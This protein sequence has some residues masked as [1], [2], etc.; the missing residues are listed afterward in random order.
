MGRDDV[1][2]VRTSKVGC[3]LHYMQWL[4]L[5]ILLLLMVDA[6]SVRNM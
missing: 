2:P 4:L 6:E 1:H 3:L 5:E